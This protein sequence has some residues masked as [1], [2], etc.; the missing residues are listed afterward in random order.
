MSLPKR[1]NDISVYKTRELTDRRYELL[2]D[3]IKSDTFF[4]EGILHDDL[5]LSVLNF[6]KEHFK[7]TSKNGTIPI[8]P[9]ILTTQRWGEITNTWTFS[10]D[11][12]VIKIPFIS[13][14]RKPEVNPG[15][16]PIS[17]KTIPDRKKFFYNIIKK[18]PKGGEIYKIPQPVSV[19]ISY[20]I[21][22][23]SQNIRELNQFNE[24][25]LRKFASKQA[26]TRAKG[27]YIPL[28]LNSVTDSSM[29]DL[30]SRKF[31]LQTYNVTLLGFIMNENEF[32]IKPLVDKFLVFT[33]IVTEKKLDRKTYNKNINVN[34][35]NFTG[36]GT[37]STFSVG[38][39][40]KLLYYVSLNGLVLQQNVDYFHIVGT[41]KI[42]F[43]V[44][45]ENNDKIIIAYSTP[46]Q[47][48]FK[49]GYEINIKREYF[50][51]DGSSLTFQTSFP[52]IDVIYLEVNGLV[53]EEYVNYVWVED[54]FSLLDT[55]VIGSVI[56]LTYFA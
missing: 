45:P 48:I 46:T 2:T 54:N 17:I 22:I 40:I 41:S 8:I 7:T 23:V 27:H 11:T 36:N 9:K 3:I 14:I 1:K 39:I 49:A 34:I 51:Y 25:V 35:V 38:E 28:V 13:V 32:E 12:D 10:D 26:Y 31:Y 50:T 33:N 56:G 24:L 18:T 47:T 30:N 16:N 53:D 4:P 5:D 43:N 52:I 44:P 21:I 19:D 37:K 20:D 6:V 55:P 15:S 42:T 29:T